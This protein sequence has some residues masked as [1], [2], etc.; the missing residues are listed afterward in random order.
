MR[1]QRTADVCVYSKLFNWVMEGSDFTEKI[2]VVNRYLA[3]EFLNR[4]MPSMRQLHNNRCAF[5][6]SLPFPSRLLVQIT[7]SMREWLSTSK[8]IIEMTDD[9]VRSSSVSPR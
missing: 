8:R 5:P 3:N 2:K 1:L 6:I 9:D 7:S 4:K